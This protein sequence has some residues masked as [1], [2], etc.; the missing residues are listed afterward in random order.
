M[1][2]ELAAA[3][4]TRRRIPPVGRKS[5]SQHDSAS[6]RESGPDRLG[7]K[8]LIMLQATPTKGLGDCERTSSARGQRE[9]SRGFLRLRAS[10]CS[11][12]VFALASR[13]GAD[14]QVQTWACPRTP[15]LSRGARALCSARAGLQV[16]PDHP[17]R[18][19]VARGGVGW[20]GKGRCL[21]DIAL[22]A[23]AT[24]GPLAALTARSA[25]TE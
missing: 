25:L 21:P 13:L 9:T 5:G 20:F 15:R 6:A 23:F 17:A 11:A 12:C 19:Y 1:V 22:T 16:C 4:H 2:E 7:F 18:H 3:L 10:A 8:H 14:S 24:P